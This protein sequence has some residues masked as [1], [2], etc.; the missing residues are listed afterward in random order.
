[1]CLFCFPLAGLSAFAGFSMMQ[2]RRYTLCRSGST[3]VMLLFPPVGIPIGI[4]VKMT[5]GIPRMR[6]AFELN[7]KVVQHEL[8][9]DE[10]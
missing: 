1:V 7:E 8:W 9:L 5:L 10:D 2:L 3:V 6:S 4:W